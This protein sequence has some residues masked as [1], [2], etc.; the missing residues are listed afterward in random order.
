MSGSI[1]LVQNH[2]RYGPAKRKA[3]LCPSG[4][5]RGSSIVGRAN[6]RVFCCLVVLPSIRSPTYLTFEESSLFGSFGDRSALRSLLLDVDLSHALLFLSS[7]L[8]SLYLS[9]R[10]S[11]HPLAAGRRSCPRCRGSPPPLAPMLV[12]EEDTSRRDRHGASSCV[13]VAAEGGARR[14]GL[15]FDS[16]KPPSFAIGESRDTCG[17]G[18]CKRRR[19][20]LCQ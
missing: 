12:A 20:P 1:V 13:G 14:G 7:P 11:M 18:G 10:A 8:L 4:G 15:C 19:A 2:G 17:G 16:S 5:K 9:T 3:V 6:D